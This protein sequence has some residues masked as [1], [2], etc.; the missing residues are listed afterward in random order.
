M[1][2]AVHPAHAANLALKAHRFAEVIADAP[3]PVRNLARHIELFTRTL[4]A[5]PRPAN[6]E[7]LEAALDTAWAEI[8]A[9]VN[10]VTDGHET[11]PDSTRLAILQLLRQ[12][13]VLS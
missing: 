6:A 5:H 2:T 12:R 11:T 4:M 8:T 9:W 3:R 7:G 13:G 10:V 1:S